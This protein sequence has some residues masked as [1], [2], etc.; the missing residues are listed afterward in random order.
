M[1]SAEGGHPLSRRFDTVHVMSGGFLNLYLNMVER[2]PWFL[3]ANF[4]T[5]VIILPVSQVSGAQLDF[6]TL[7]LD[8]TP[9]LPKPESF[10]RFARAYMATGQVINLFN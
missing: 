9:I 6:D 4:S 8:S 3:G 5:L 2:M 10:T 1:S 7:I